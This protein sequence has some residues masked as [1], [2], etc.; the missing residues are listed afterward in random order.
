[1]LTAN[2]L[3]MLTPHFIF[4]INKRILKTFDIKI[5]TVFIQTSVLRPSKN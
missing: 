3:T 2:T 4:D 1:M 5:Y